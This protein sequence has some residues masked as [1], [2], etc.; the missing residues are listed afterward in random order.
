[1]IKIIEMHELKKAPIFVYR[2]TCEK[3][4]SVFECDRDDFRYELM[5][6]GEGGLAINCPVCDNFIHEMYGIGAKKWEVIER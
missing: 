1:M 2:I 3:C 5:G 6:Q 4:N